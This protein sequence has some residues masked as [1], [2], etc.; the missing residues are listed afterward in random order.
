MFALPLLFPVFVTQFL[1]F[2]NLFF[3]APV[4]SWEGDAM[5][6]PTCCAMML[7]TLGWNSSLSECYLFHCTL[8]VCDALFWQC[9]TIWCETI[10]WSGIR[11]SVEMRRHCV[12]FFCESMFFCNELYVF[13]SFF[14]FFFKPILK[15]LALIFFFFLLWC[16]PARLTTSVARSKNGIIWICYMLW[17]SNF[18][19]ISKKYYS[20]QILKIREKVWV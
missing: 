20:F 2:F 7:K 14:F 15:S 9:L 4:Q 19:G 16:K 8:C 1:F 17:S 12:E 10:C 6:I 11:R 18:Q 5:T 13:L 3:I